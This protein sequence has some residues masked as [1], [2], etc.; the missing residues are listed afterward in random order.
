LVQDCNDSN[1]GSKLFAI[2]LQVGTSLVTLSPAPGFVSTYMPVHTCFCLHITLLQKSYSPFMCTLLML[3]QWRHWAS[4]SSAHMTPT[5]SHKTAGCTHFGTLRDLQKKI[6]KIQLKYIHLA[7]ISTSVWFST[8][9]FSMFLNK[10]FLTFNLCAINLY[11][12]RKWTVFKKLCTCGLKFY[13]FK[14][15]THYWRTFNTIT[16]FCICV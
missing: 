14:H 1:V 15:H 6:W 16:M 3:A 12:W 11:D 5:P 13:C 2:R 4:I 7:H 9:V 10:M 8:L